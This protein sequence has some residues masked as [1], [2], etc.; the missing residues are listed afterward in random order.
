MYRKRSFN[1]TK[2]SASHIILNVK[3]TEND[4]SGNGS[5]SAAVNSL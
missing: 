1:S 5:G 2:L 4:H 3:L